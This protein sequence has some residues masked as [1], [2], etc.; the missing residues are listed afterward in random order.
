MNPSP[1]RLKDLRANQVLGVV[2]LLISSAATTQAVD[3]FWT[4]TTGTYNNASDWGGTIPNGSDNA[5]V[6]SGG[7]VL[8]NPADPNWTVNET[9]AGDGNGNTGA[10]QQDGPTVTL[11]GWFRLGLGGGTGS[12]LFKS[13]TLNDNGRFNIGEGGTAT[14]SATNTTANNTVTIGSELWCGNGTG[15]SGTVNLGGNA[16]LSVN[17]WL[18]IGRDGSTGVLNLFGNASITKI[19]GGNITFAGLTGAT[20]NG[21]LNQTGGAVTNETSET[22]L[23]EDGIGVW[24][25]NAG[26]ASLALL[27]FGRN[28]SA[29]GTFNL[30]GGILSVNQITLGSGSGGLNF[31]GGTLRARASSGNFMS[32]ATGFL[33][34][35]GAILDSQGFDITISSTLVDADGGGLTKGG[36]G[37][38][39]LTGA[40][41]YIGATIVTAGKLIEGTASLVTS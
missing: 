30:N 33:L 31:N 36:S 39:T 32:G 41:T 11:N 12:Y 35:G 1:R 26:S 25:M 38:A 29:N 13:G 21:T 3:R 2:C 19:G 5:I 15:A 18:A 37:T 23:S 20:A 16:R 4:G 34:A 8:I 22:W 17:N 27:Q 10:W 28:G 24:N 7:T 40:N 14:F 9:R 6:N